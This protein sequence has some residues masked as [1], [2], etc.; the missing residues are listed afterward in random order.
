MKKA[1]RYINFFIV[2]IVFGL[3]LWWL[4]LVTDQSADVTKESGKATLKEQIGK[5]IRLSYS[6]EGVYP[7]SI[8]YLEKNYGLRIDE[9]YFVH[10]EVFADNIMPQYEVYDRPD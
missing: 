5:T 1:T 10:Y 7:P 9:K 3:L 8:E 6:I 4:V 2:V